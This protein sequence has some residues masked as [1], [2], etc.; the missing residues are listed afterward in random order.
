MPRRRPPRAITSRPPWVRLAIGFIALVV[1][2]LVLFWGAG[3][4][5]SHASWGS[6]LVDAVVFTIIV[7]AVPFGARVLACLLADLF[8]TDYGSP[9]VPVVT[10]VG[11]SVGLVVG[12][13]GNGHLLGAVAGGALV[14]GFAWLIATTTIG[15]RLAAV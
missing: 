1:G 5:R 10:W 6:P 13:A 14:G 12:I 8:E 11:V 2:S 9:Q 7:I 3:M 15:R 4:E